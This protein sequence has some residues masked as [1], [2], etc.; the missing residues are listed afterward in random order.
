MP[1]NFRVMVAGFAHHIVQR[2]S[3]GQATFLTPGDRQVYLEMASRQLAPSGLRLIAYCLMTNHV[4][5]IA[6]PERGDSL[7]T[8]VQRV[9]GRYAQYL[10]ARTGR[11]GHL[12]HHRYFACVLSPKHLTV[13]LRYVEQ[14]PVR[15]GLIRGDPASYE[16]SSC[17]AHVTGVLDPFL[18]RAEWDLRGGTAG[19]RDL[20]VEP[21]RKPVQH[22]LR[23]C[24]FAGRPFGD[25]AFLTSMEA[26]TGRHWPRWS[27]AQ[28]LH[29]QDVLLTLE[30][31]TPDYNYFEAAT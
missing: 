29:D 8:W 24:T 19:W 25:E 2:G 21:D 18:D 11:S 7:S 6:V 5:L 17:R 4:H 31:L 22:L 30:K 28:S 1:R 15:A 3:N 27:Y 9:H 13:A 16:W 14:N 23:R 20:L 26:Q 10:N 12:W